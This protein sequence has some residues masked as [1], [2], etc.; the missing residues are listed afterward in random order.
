MMSAT[1]ETHGVR[2]SELLGDRAIPPG[3]DRTVLDISV[4]SRTVTPGCLFF[5]CA[6]RT[7]HGLDFADAA[8]DAGAAAIVWEP[9]EGVAADD[10]EA[11]PLISMPGLSAKLGHIADR[12]FSAPSR[13][14]RVAGVTGTN[15]KSTSVHLISGAMES[16]GRA[17]GCVGTLGAGRPGSAH[18]T[19]LTTPDV[20]SM[21]RMLRQLR[22]DGAN[23]AALEVSSH[24]L[25]QGRVNGVRFDT[26]IFTNLSRDHLDYH[27]DAGRYAARKQRLFTEFD[28]RNAVLNI[29]DDYGRQ[30]VAQLDLSRAPIAVSVTGADI[31][32]G[33][34]HISARIGA[35]NFSGLKLEIDSS[36]GSGVLTSPLIGEFNATNLCL[37]AGALLAWET[38]FEAA[39]ASLSTVCAPRGRMEIIRGGEAAPTVVVDYAHTPAALESVLHVLGTFGTGKIVCVF[40]CGG[41]RDRGK[42]PEMGRIAAARADRIILTDDNPRLEAPAEI[43]AAIQ[44]GIPADA[45][46][47]VEHDRRAAIRLAI[48]R[49]GPD[50]VIL[51]A[52][53][54]HETQQHAGD[55]VVPFDDCAVAGAILRNAV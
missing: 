18:A 31:P 25:D 4:D 35:D 20:I 44:A 41:D 47:T 33:C 30:L 29:D 3:A 36:W 51:I 14:L 32:A 5:A 50:D 19:A 38:S 6:G 7:R 23:F 28:Y 40:G 13:S 49:A 11:A 16:Q 24:G 9:A 52:G 10:K 27:G 22:D 1:A 21:H 2:L 54:G 26:V 53:K 12:F 46:V 37:A 43:I 42:R 55:K 8:L 17:C 15:G 48:S 39:M 45:E 34:R